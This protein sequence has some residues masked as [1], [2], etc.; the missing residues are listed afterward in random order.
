MRRS[1]RCCCRRRGRRRRQSEARLGAWIAAHGER[2]FQAAVTGGQYEYP[3][4]LFFGG[5][6]PTWS[7]RTLRA[8]LRRH[9][10]ARE[11][12][13]AI[14]FHTGLGPRG[15]GEK[16]YNGRAVAADI[17]ARASGGGPT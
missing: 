6:E 13:A 4:G 7:N 8:V 11:R 16:I 5:A 10:A 1:T 12:L 15:H 2:A 14:D 3:D 9:A 17:A